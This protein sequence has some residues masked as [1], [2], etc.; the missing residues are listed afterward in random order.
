[1]YI[2]PEC[3]REYDTEEKVSKCFLKCWKDNNPHYQSKSAP[4]SA[5]INTSRASED[6]LQFFNSLERGDRDAGG[7]G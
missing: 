1:M 5:D 3:G 6:I 2:C 7:I 4:R